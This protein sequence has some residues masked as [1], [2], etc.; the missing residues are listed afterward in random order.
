MKFII[1]MNLSPDWIKPL[2]GVGIE[3]VHWSTI[4]LSDAPDDQIMDYAAANGF[5]VLTN[6]LDFG[7]ALALTNVPKPSV[8]QLRMDEL[9]PLIIGDRLI[10]IL[11]RVGTEFE[12]GALITV[13]ETR[14][15]LRQLPFEL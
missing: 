4:G 11:L 9:D 8:V 13:E 5:V 14:V 12:K 1:D 7:A 2:D 6:D 3:A 15:R 10:S